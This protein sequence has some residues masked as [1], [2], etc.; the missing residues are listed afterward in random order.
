MSMKPQPVPSEDQLANVG[1]PTR[2][3]APVGVHKTEAR[4]R[5]RSNQRNGEELRAGKD[6]A[7]A[8]PSTADGVDPGHPLTPLPSPGTAL[9]RACQAC[10][11]AGRFSLHHAAYRG[12]LGCMETL[13]SRPALNVSAADQRGRHPLF[14]AAA[15][16]HVGACALLLDHRP[17]LIDCGDDNADTALHVASARGHDAVVQLLVE[18]G[19]TVNLSNQSGLTP[20]HVA[21]TNATLRLLAEYGG[22]I[23]SVDFSG[24]TPLFIMCA[25]GR[26][27]AAALLCDL[28]ENLQS[29]TMADD[30]GDTPLHASACN[31][32]CRCLQ[33]LLQYAVDFRLRNNH[34]YTA[35]ELARMNGHGS[36]MRMLQRYT[37]VAQQRL[38]IE[39]AEAMCTPLET[40]QLDFQGEAKPALRTCTP[41]PWEPPASSLPANVELLFSQKN[42]ARLLPQTTS[43]DRWYI[44]IRTS[45]TQMKLPRLP[46]RHLPEHANYPWYCFTDPNSQLLYYYNVVTEVSQWNPPAEW[47]S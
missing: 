41:G 14:Y 28:D 42:Q 4:G 20:V 17:D 36:C 24:R 13:F 46:G 23:F 11:R 19:A 29:L 30:R 31:G 27:D 16:G 6:A 40:P 33:L 47:I 9:V 10:E 7:A 15:R 8:A 38:S 21:T 25:T 18:A 43:P 1:Q 35:E 37:L 26:F 32:H 45:A 12:H 44:S 22:G 34:G 2:D 39:E 3:A 5:L